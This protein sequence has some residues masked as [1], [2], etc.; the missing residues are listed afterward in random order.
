MGEC[1]CNMQ[2]LRGKLTCIDRYN[3]KFFAFINSKSHLESC[4]VEEL[5][6]V[7]GNTVRYY[8]KYYYYYYTDDNITATYATTYLLTY[9][10]THSME[11]SQS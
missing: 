7:N 6:V 3:H 4:R 9:L 10:P 11:Q 5:M 2:I 1:V 8:K